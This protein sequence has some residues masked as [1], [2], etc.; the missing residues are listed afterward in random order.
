[1]RLPRVRFTIQGQM[2]TVAFLA[3]ALALVQI[4]ARSRDRLA[5]AA[6]HD[7]QVEFWAAVARHIETQPLTR[8]LFWG[9]TESELRAE[10]QGAL[11]LHRARAVFHASLAEKYREAA[12]SPWLP[13]TPDPPE[14]E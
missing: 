7:R 6:V 14:P 2:V 1:M 4:R 13:M 10:R 5:K 9:A 12:R 8:R 11:R 3:M